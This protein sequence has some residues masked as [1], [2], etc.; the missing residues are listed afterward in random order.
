[1]RES[2]TKPD[3]I[4]TFFRFFL[5]L[6]IA[7]NSRSLPL[8][9]IQVA[10]EGIKAM[11]GA[12]ALNLGKDEEDGGTRIL[13]THAGDTGISFREQNFSSRHARARMNRE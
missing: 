12:D 1:M 3:V 6:Y 9:S 10:E 5:F 11:L 4:Q 2:R 7:R 13:K 8:V